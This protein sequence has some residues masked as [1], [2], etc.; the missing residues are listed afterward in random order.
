MSAPAQVDTSTLQD[1]PAINGYGLKIATKLHAVMEKLDYLQK[2]KFNQQQKY[3]YA[4]D[5]AIT[6]AVHE[7]LLEHRILFDLSFLGPPVIME[8][9]PGNKMRVA[10][11]H[12]RY[13]YTDLDSGEQLVGEWWG[14]GADSTDKH[15]YKAVT[16]AKKYIH[17]STFQIAT[18]DDPEGSRDAQEE[19]AATKLDEA[20]SRLEQAQ[21]RAK[22]PPSPRKAAA[23]SKSA[24]ASTPRPAASSDTVNLKKL[25][26]ELSAMKQ[27]LIDVEPK[28]GAGLEF[29][30]QVLTAAGAKTGKA[31][32]RVFMATPDKAR[33]V[34]R[35][36][37]L[38][39]DEWKRAE[40]GPGGHLKLTDD[41]L[42]ITQADV[43][44]VS[45][46]ADAD[47]MRVRF[48]DLG[49]QLQRV[50]DYVK[51]AT[52]YS[53]VASFLEHFAE[54]LETLMAIVDEWEQDSRAAA[55]GPEPVAPAKAPAGW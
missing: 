20:A 15:L 9:A 46:S 4:S 1:L 53:S 31:N 27:K 34:W 42:G 36:L 6:R 37:T 30:R 19:V 3:G 12:L 55:P 40:A 32:D 24:A 39:L 52:E 41:E 5:E 33:D 7:Q 13:R 51:G 35:L 54:P 14:S 25:I 2:D 11:A 21:A 10:L 43:D 26:G 47:P 16:G 8:P 29:Y 28:P 18:G 44:A 48:D 17:L 22:N 49:S 50:K 45:G 23:A 38:K